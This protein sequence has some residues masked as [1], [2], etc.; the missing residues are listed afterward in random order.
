MDMNDLMKKASDKC[1]RVVYATTELWRFVYLINFEE[2]LCLCTIQ[3]ETFQGR[4]L[5]TLHRQVDV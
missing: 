4:Y 2:L 5:E 1:Q 3:P